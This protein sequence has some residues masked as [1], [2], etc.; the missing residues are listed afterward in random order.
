MNR[1]KLSI[2][3]APSG[4]VVTLAEVK[5]HL[6]ID[7]DD[8]YDDDLLNAYIATAVERSE[9]ITGRALLRTT[10][11]LEIDTWREV[12]LPKP[13]FVSITSIKYIDTDGN[14]QTLSTSDYEIDDAREPTQIYFKVNHQLHDQL[15]PIEIV[16]QAGYT[17]A[18]AI[19]SG[20]K[21]YTKM[22]VCDYYDN[23]RT[24]SVEKQM[25][26]SGISRSLIT[27]YIVTE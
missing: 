11:K 6:R 10:Y 24:S 15:R 19:P 13:P 20:I 21:Q 26:S 5:Q 18:A 22:V 17:N 25:M 16:Y 14:E 3:T 12:Q 7:S 27:P 8:T 4:S 9:I 2:T 1:S 23:A